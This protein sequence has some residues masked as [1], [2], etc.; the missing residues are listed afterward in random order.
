[1]GQWRSYRRQYVLAL[2]IS[3][4]LSLA[5]FTFGAWRNNSFSQF[6]YLPFNLVLAWLPFVLAVRLIA[7]VKRKLWSSWEALVLSILWLIF[8]PNSFYMISDFVHLQDVKRVNI[9]FDT[10]MFT[11]FIYTAVILGYSS[12]YLIHVRL[13][14]RLSNNQSA[15]IVAGTLLLS[16][17][18]IYL[19]RDLRWSSWDIFTNPGGLLFDISDRLQHPASYPT[20]ILTVSVFFVVL[21]SM[22]N[23]LWKATS[24]FRH[25]NIKAET[26][27][28][29]T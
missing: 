10:L 4:L 19:G 22:Y 25:Q 14:K 27:P 21:V 18:A 16:S 3:S 8:I 20:M 17:I 5:L 26:I 24:L 23:L 6:S 7:V 12:L 2:L 1:M 11:T 28:H 9:L 15:G 29:N 13:R